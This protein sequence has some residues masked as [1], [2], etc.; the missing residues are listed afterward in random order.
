MR[1][2]CLVICVSACSTGGVDVWGGQSSVVEVRGYSFKVIHSS[3]R[4]EAF[5]LTSKRRP[6]SRVIFAAA[7]RAME[8]VSG[9]RVVKSSL[10]GDVALI[11]ADLLC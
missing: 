11:K 5:R 9:C 8:I 4:A 3:E 6:K 1:W 10:S 7:G 2:L